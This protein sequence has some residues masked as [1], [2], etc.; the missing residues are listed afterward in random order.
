MAMPD[1][2]GLCRTRRPRPPG[3]NGVPAR[4]SPGEYRSRAADR[5]GEYQ[6]GSQLPRRMPAPA[7]GDSPP[8]LQRRPGVHPSVPNVRQSSVL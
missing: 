2:T 4:S 8:A 7:L 1:R 3:D 6:Q 5:T